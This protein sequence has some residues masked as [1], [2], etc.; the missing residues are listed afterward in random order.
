MSNIPAF[1]TT[2]FYDEKIVGVAPGMTLRD[3]FAAAALP[4]LVALYAGNPALIATEAYIQ[5]DAMLMR[6]GKP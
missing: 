5:A 4:G 3:Y 2:E 1:P 6:R